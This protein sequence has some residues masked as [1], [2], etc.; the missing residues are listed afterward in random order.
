MLTSLYLGLLTLVF[1][2]I[3]LDTIKLRQKNKIS[4]GSGPN[5]EI[6]GHVAAHSNFQAYVPL[7]GILLYIYEGSELAFPMII[8]AL[9]LSVLSGRLLHY[10]GI[11]DT[12]APNFKFRSVGMRLTLIPLAILAIL[13]IANFVYV[14][15]IKG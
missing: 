11:K 5:D 12:K 4:L 1:F 15:R 8:H 10:L 6:A 9:G 7:F 2:K 13:N 14:T 3:S